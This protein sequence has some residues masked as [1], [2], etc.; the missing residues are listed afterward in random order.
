[1][2]TEDAEKE[3]LMTD[4]ISAGPG[5][6]GVS[7]TLRTVVSHGCMHT[8]VCVCACIVYVERIE[9]GR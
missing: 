6:R 1:M 3:G 8:N 5:R 4:K 9:G 7:K 2:L